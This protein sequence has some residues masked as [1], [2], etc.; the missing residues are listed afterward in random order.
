MGENDQISI[1][2]LEAIRD[3]GVDLCCLLL[4]TDQRVQVHLEHFLYLFDLKLFFCCI[5]NRKKDCPLW[6]GTFLLHND[7]RATFSID[8]ESRSCLFVTSL[9]LTCSVLH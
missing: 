9:H 4:A 3:K 5:V 7:I 1:I 8:C 6:L 2:S